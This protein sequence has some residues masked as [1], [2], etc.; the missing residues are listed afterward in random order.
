MRYIIKVKCGKRYCSHEYTIE[1]FHGHPLGKALKKLFKAGYRNTDERLSSLEEIYA[2][3][4]NE[5][6]EWDEIRFNTHNN[7]GCKKV[8]CMGPSPLNP[9]E[10]VKYVTVDYMINL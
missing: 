3:W 5:L 1:D 4:R 9:R 2:R 6:L 7:V 8:F 10:G